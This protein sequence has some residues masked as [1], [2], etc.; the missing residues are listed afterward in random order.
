MKQSIYRLY[1]IMYQHTA[2]TIM[3][4]VRQGHYETAIGQHWAKQEVR[5]QLAQAAE[6]RAMT[7]FLPD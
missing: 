7:G 1:M 5:R 4:Q 6:C 3:G 2:R